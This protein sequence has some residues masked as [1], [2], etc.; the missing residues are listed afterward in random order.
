MTEDIK[1]ALKLYGNTIIS[2]EGNGIDIYDANMT[3]ITSECV[4]YSN[5]IGFFK[6]PLLWIALKILGRKYMKNRKI[7]SLPNNDDVVCINF[8]SLPEVVIE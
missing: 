1:C 5:N 8:H 3:A 6:D 2:H 4:F 7:K